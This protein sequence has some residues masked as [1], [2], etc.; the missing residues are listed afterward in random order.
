MTTCNTT[1]A[2]DTGDKHT[3]HRPESDLNGQERRLSLWESWAGGGREGCEGE[4]EG[5]WRWRCHSS[6]T[7]FFATKLNSPLS[8]RVLSSLLP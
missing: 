2:R 1:M 6:V 3:D 7:T 8:Q 5:R 4:R